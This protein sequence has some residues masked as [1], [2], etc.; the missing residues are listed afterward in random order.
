MQQRVEL[1][2]WKTLPSTVRAKIEIKLFDYWLSNFRQNFFDQVSLFCSVSFHFIS[3]TWS[4]SFIFPLLF[5]YIYLGPSRFVLY[6]MCFVFYVSYFRVS[7]CTM[8]VDVHVKYK[9]I[10]HYRQYL[11][12]EIKNHL[13]QSEFSFFVKS[14]ILLSNI[15]RNVERK[16]RR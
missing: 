16:T 12:L 10:D 4:C 6:I 1:N 5:I 8:S 11:Q 9:N 3:Q 13:K 2:A 15:E 7:K 14:F